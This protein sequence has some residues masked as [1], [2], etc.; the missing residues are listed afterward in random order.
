MVMV[1]AYSAA[2]G[3]VGLDALTAAVGEALPAYRSRHI[4]LNVA[5][6][7]AGHEAVDRL[8]AP[9]WAAVPA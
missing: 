8:V 4:E 2:T 7:R 6:L 1:G 9:A 5:A 3:L